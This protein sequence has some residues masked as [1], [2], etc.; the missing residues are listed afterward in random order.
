MAKT[1]GFIL[2]RR[3]ALAGGGVLVA[4][5][6]T[7]LWRTLRGQD[8]TTSAAAVPPPPHACDSHVHVI[9]DIDRFPMS[10]DRDY[11]PFAA[12]TPDL[13]QMLDR[14]GLERVV[15]VNPDVYATDNAA[16]LDA[17]SQLGPKRA[18]G[19][20]AISKHADQQE[21]STLKAGGIVG[22]R[23]VLYPG[24]AFDAARTRALLIERL[25]L[26]A[27]YGWHLDLATV[28]D[29]VAAVQTE[30]MTSPVP[31]ALD[32]FGWVSDVRQPGFDVIQSLLRT[33]RIYVKLSEPYRLSNQR[34]DYPDLAPVA[35]ALVTANPDRILWGSGWPHVAGPRQG[36][37]KGALSPNLSVDDGHLLDLLTRW[38]PDEATR[39][40]I[41]VDNPAR[42]YGF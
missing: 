6:G 11:T 26:A 28:P 37:A 18:R 22:F 21:F 25:K 30:L 10:P 1:D 42:L 13:R 40:K 7:G 20:A 9:A 39:H 36:A 5:S 16:T 35:R 3:T 29:I 2:T 23:L 19:I 15:I 34:P 38:A 12:T 27:T 4:A 31:V 33:G 24:D 14:L 32:Y 17:V 8:P 41:L